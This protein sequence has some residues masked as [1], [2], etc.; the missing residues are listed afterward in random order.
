MGRM[1][2]WASLEAEDPEIAQVVRDE[3][4]RTRS[5]LEL[6]ASENYP[7]LAVLE[8]MGTVLT[9]KYAE[10]YPGRRYYGGCEVVD[11]AE[12][13]ARDRAKEL[14]GAE[15]VNVQPHA[16][17]QANMAVYHALLQRGDTV[18]G[19]SLDQGGHLTHGS[20][21]NFSGQY[22]NFVAY[23]V[24]RESHRIDMDEV[25]AL[26][27]EH[28]PKMIVT[29]ATAYPRIWDFAAFREIAEEVDAYL[30][31]DMAHFAGLVAAGVHPNPVPH[32]HVV[33]TT[34]HKTLRGPRGGMILCTADLAKPIDKAVF[35]AIQG[36]PLMHVIAA[37]AVALRQAMSDE[38]RRDQART[39]SNAQTLASAL[40]EAGASIVSGGTDNHLMLVDVRPLGVTGKEADAALG[41]VHVTVNKNTIPYDPN[42]PMVASG[43]R[44]GTPAVTSRGMGD[45]EMREIATLIVE[46]IAVRDDPARQ[47]AIRARVASIADRFPVPGLPG[48]R[49]VAQAP[50]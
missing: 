32:S 44:V 42:P 5:N 6:I 3:E 33:A 9:G 18:M 37:K 25:R 21:V 13:L 28:R 35:P 48:T 36:G 39:V 38:F 31:T 8:A 26:A 17:A 20:P 19:L 2:L 49:A 40:A 22:Y 30:F 46:G 11:V 7:S 1:D 45:A 43:I 24:D 27:R 29:G 14:F 23:H 16:G 34:T 50:A 4:E 10:G 47:G 15:H 41:E 12:N